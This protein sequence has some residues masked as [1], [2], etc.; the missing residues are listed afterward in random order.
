MGSRPRADEA[1]APSRRAVLAAM[2]GVPLSACLSPT[3]SGRPSPALTIYAP[4]PPE[5]P[6]HPLNL[7]LERAVHSHA[8]GLSISTQP[9]ALPESI[10]RIL[11]VPAPMRPYHLPIVTTVDLPLA[12]AGAGPDWHRYPVA[13]P[14]LLFVS[15][16]YD[17]GFG[18]QVFDDTITS[19]DQLRGR[20]IAAPA[21]PSAVRLLT[22]ALLGDGWG[23][24]D[25]VALVDSRPGDVPRLAAEGAIAGAS[26]NLILPGAAGPAPMLG[27][28][29]G[30]ARYLDIDAGALNRVTAVRGFT[31]RRFDGWKGHHLL[32]FA[33][34]LAAWAATPDDVVEQ[35]LA[36]IEMGG[37]Q[38]PGLPDT[39]SAMA[40]WP[41]LR[42][43]ELHPAA[44]RYLAAR[45]MRLS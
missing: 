26:W 36:A 23:V 33:Q 38:A 7:D 18:I 17:V 28:R 29:A 12:R 20:R 30:G 1:R 39:A 15:T 41:A 9:V 8:P 6:L 14:D 32:S 31:A 37:P 11:A 16:L 21:R 10:N 35:V 22:E 42:Q 19:P 45:G 40:D 5:T 4:A 24:L 25:D 13:S 3:G 34:A 27:E 44:R 2:T 43:D